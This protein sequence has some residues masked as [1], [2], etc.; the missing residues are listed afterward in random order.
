MHQNIKIL[1]NSRQQAIQKNDL[2]LENVKRLYE[3]EGLS[4]ANTPEA[5]FVEGALLKGPFDT[6]LGL[7]SKLSKTIKTVKTIINLKNLLVK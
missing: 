1:E 2:K 6:I 4:T 5:L 7:V 3:N